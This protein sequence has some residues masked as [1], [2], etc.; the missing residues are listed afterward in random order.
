[1]GPTRKRTRRRALRTLA[2]GALTASAG[3]LKLDTSALRSPPFGPDETAEYRLGATTSAWVGLEPPI[4]AQ[5]RNPT[6]EF[7]PEQRVEITWV[8]L[9][10]NPHQ[11]LVE[12][13]TGDVLVRSETTTTEGATRTVTFEARQEMVEYICDFHPVQMRGV[14]LVTRN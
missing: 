13:S 12:D 5:L 8:N 11:L 9:D 10:G 1:M 4:I 6:L 2:G 7:A 3:C 14:I